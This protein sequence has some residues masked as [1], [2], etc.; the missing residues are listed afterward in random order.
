MFLYLTVMLLWKIWHVTMKK[1]GK[2]IMQNS[3]NHILPIG[4]DRKFTPT[5]NNEVKLIL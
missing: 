2:D 4:W 1:Q 5:Q 3:L